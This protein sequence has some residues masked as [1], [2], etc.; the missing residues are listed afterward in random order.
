[1]RRLITGIDPAGR[2]CVVAETEVRVPTRPVDVWS[3]YR[4]AT[5]SAPPRPPGRAQTR[6]L[7]VAPGSISWVVSRWDAGSEAAA[8]HHSDPSALDVVLAG[9]ID[10]LPDD[11]EHRLEQGD[12]V[13]IT[14]VDHGWRA[15][16]AGCTLSVV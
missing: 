9:T 8:M 7:G 5:N 10:L 2:S 16:S 6:D 14:G 12:C 3:L 1:M 11:G 15:G 13:I 4:T